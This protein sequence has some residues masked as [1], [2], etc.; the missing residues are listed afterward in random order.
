KLERIAA[1]YSYQLKGK[2][3]AEEAK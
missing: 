3:I 2:K 1:F